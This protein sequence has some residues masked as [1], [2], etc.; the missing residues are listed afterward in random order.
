MSMDPSRRTLLKRSSALFGAS[1][2]ASHIA[3]ASRVPLHAESS[4]PRLVHLSFNENPYG[5]SPGVA[6][7]IQHEF[8]RLNR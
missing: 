7:A 8:N 2:V 3:D 4:S 1:I 5:P 6:E